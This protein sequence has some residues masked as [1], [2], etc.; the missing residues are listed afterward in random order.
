MITGV[1]RS[2]TKYIQTILNR[3]GMNVGHEKWA[4]D[5]DGIVSWKFSQ[6]PYDT[7]TIVHQVRDPLACIS[8]LT[9]IMQ[10]SI[11]YMYKYIKRPLTT[12]KLEICMYLWLKWNQYIENNLKPDYT[13]RIEDIDKAIYGFFTTIDYQY[14][15]MIVKRVLANTPKNVHSRSHESFTWADLFTA[16]E[17]LAAGIKDYAEVK[18]Y[19]YEE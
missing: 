1:G 5:M 9:T 14:N 12:N 8:S 3:I 10:S 18:G 4:E 16:N 17:K 7:T 6:R 19:I 2:G 11:L 13:M 15:E